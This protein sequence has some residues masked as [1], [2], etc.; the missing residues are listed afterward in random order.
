MT[1]ELTLWDQV[2]KTDPTYTKQFKRPG[3]FQGTSIN[4]SYM[5]KRAS[6]QFGPIGL[7]W[8]VDVVQEDYREGAPCICNSVVQ[9][10]R[11]I[12]H[13]VKV[14]LWYRMPGFEDIGEVFHFGQTP[15]VFGTK[16][17]VKTDEEAPKKSMTDATNKALSMLGFGGDIY[18][19]LYDDQEYRQQVSDEAL[20][21]KA[22]N[23]DEELARQAKD[24]QEWKIEH[25]KLAQT[26]RSLAELRTLYTLMVR[27]MGRHNDASGLQALEALKD[28]RQDELRGNTTTKEEAPQ[29]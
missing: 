3:G 9:E 4:S 24:Y 21:D 12:I 26:A 15:F 2:Q 1:E 20:V 14:R 6:E 22:D 28:E 29:S 5:A 25:M 13:I 19:G 18:L 10:I 7:G 23:K 27:R 16:Y 17:G 11:E 8:G